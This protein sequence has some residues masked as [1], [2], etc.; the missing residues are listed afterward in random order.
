MDNHPSA[1]RRLSGIAGSLI[2]D[3]LG[4]VKSVEEIRAEAGSPN[5]FHFAARLCD[6]SGL[7]GQGNFG[8]AYTAAA[9]REFAAARALT[10]AVALYCAAFSDR[11]DSPLSSRR[12]A[13][14]PCLSPEELALYS[15]AQYDDQ[16]FP[17]TAF[18][19]DTPLHWTPAVDPL[20]GETLYVPSAM[21]FLPYEADEEAGEL[22]IVQPT[23]TGLACHYGPHEAAVEA[24][25]DVVGCDALML[26]WQARLSMP[27]LRVE[28]LSDYNYDLVSRFE[29]TGGSVTLLDL[30]TDTRVLTVLACL[31][32]AHPTAP[33]LVFGAATDPE[34]ENAVRRSLEELALSHRHAQQ[35]KTYVPRLEPETN[36]ENVVSQ[37]DHINFWCDHAHAP[38]ADFLFA[39]PER[40]E[41]D[42][43]V[44]HA[45][46]SPRQD[47][48]LLLDRIRAAGHRPLLADL[49]TPDVEQV[50]LRVVRALVPGLHPLFIGYGLRALGGSRLWGVARQFGAKEFGPGERDNPLPHPFPR[51]GV[52]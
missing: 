27:Q 26:T 40:V 3:Q 5:F 50:G 51:K 47:L 10:D 16:E 24:L 17:F 25:C 21:V 36:H 28:T 29:Q 42:Q 41:F 22:P 9:V 37:L 12:D 11:A 1:R 23:S 38:S 44:S 39:S 15:P 45:T 18:D 48:R 14:F 19:D 8:T 32:N 34:P 31:R 2:D 43:L 4:V 46:G 13:D 6:T 35:I 52:A 33:A 7:A 30:T 49:T 20:G